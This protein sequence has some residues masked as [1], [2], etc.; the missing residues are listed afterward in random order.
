MKK[1]VKRLAIRCASHP[2]AVIGIALLVS[3]LAIQAAIQLPVY[4]S[5]QALLPQNTEVA[6]R[7]NRFLETFGAASDLV[8]ALENAP[9]ETME[10]FATELA[11][12][13][14]TQ[15][16]IAQAAERLD[17]DFFLHQAYLIMP[18]SQ[19]KSPS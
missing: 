12:N 5:R 9:R 6:A 13:L 1:L 8:V 14:R 7:L 2:F 10:A 16:E 3:L 19:L 15:P 11:S 4:T 18:V 17:T